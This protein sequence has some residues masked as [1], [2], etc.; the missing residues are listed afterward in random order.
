MR[1]QIMTKQSNFSQMHFPQI[2]QLY[3]LFPNLPFIFIKA[4]QRNPR[5]SHGLRIRQGSAK[6]LIVPADNLL[7]RFPLSAARSVSR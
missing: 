2:Y 5:L 6:R 4:F 1:N 3:T 7:C